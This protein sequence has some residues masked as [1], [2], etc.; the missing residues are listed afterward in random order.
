MK[1]AGY[2]SA[3]LKILAVGMWRQEDSL[4]LTGH[5]LAKL[6]SFGFDERSRL[7]KIR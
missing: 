4:V 1:N 7:K 5:S 6:A 3:H 2:S